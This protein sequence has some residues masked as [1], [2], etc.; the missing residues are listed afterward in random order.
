MNTNLEELKNNLFEYLD[1]EPIRIKYE[2]LGNEDSRFYTHDLYIAINNKYINDELEIIKCLIHE[3][4]HYYQLVVVICEE[5]FNPQYKYWKKEF[6]N[7]IKLKP[8]DAMCQYIEI[9]AFA[10]TKYI[11]KE[12]LNIEYHHHDKKYDEILDLFIK[13]YY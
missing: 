3:I 5:D 1:L 8:E 7:K 9:D 4:R 11:L 12:W 13:K 10:F 6:K 2:D